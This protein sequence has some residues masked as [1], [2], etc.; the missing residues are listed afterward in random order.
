MMI[1]G[2]VLH[3]ICYDFFF[4]T[5][6]IYTDRAAPPGIRAQAQGM[7]VLF[8]L[9]LGMLIGAQVA[10]VIEERNTPAESVALSA[11]VQQLGGRI[12][13]L[14]EQAA[15]GTT[16]LDEEITALSAEQTEK[17]IASLAAINW[18][19]IWTIPAGLAALILLLF[20]LFFREDRESQR[21]V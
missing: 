5:G 20:A 18:R 11:E 9:G 12:A 14:E 1:A 21:P 15:A 8:T 19:A 4:V 7:L 13:A 16:G 6:Q 10:G 17:S 3:G 2:I